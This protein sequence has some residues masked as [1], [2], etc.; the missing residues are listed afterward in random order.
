[1]SYI[2][3]IDESIA[4]G[5][6]AELY[7]RVGNPDGTV[8]NVMKIHSL[9]PESLK[10]HFDLYVVALHRP[11]PLSR[12]ERE[13]VGTIVSRL[14]ECEYCRTHHAAGL[15]RLLPD[16]RKQL[17]D[18]LA[19]G[20]DTGLTPRESAMAE[21]ASK[22]ARHPGGVRRDDVDE[23]R[24]AGL[25]DRSILDLAQVVAYF[26]YANRIVNGLGAE[27]EL[28]DLGQHPHTD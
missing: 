9:S 27:I 22:L 25:D 6:L 13:I 14:N 5:A 12:V 17:A 8:D 2:E 18:Q 15:K 23:L 1:M 28:F 3:M 7:K 20:D 4:S 10:A 24:A 26:C 19:A 11:S 16:D 21:Y